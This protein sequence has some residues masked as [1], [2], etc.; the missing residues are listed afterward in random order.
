MKIES[1]FRLLIKKAN[2]EGRYSTANAYQCTLH[3]YQQFNKNTLVTF[4]E[5]T[6]EHMK[7]YEQDMMKRGLKYN[8]ISLYFRMLRAVCNQAVKQ[9]IAQINTFDLFQHVFMGNKPTLKRAI[10][11]AIISKLAEADLSNEPQL[12]YCR[13]LFLL[14]VYLQGIP[15]I[16]L[17]YMRKSDITGN[18]L[19]YFRHKTGSSIRVT[20]ES[21][22]AKIMAK[23][24]AQCKDSIYV[25]PII[26]EVGE[27]GHKQYCSALRLYN[28]HLNQL[29]MQLNLGVKLSS[30][31]ARHTWATTAK[32]IGIPISII[33]TGMGHS[34]EKMTS[35][36]LDSF[37]DKKT[38]DANKKVIAA[39][40]KERKSEK[41]PILIR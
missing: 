1:F 32:N 4:E 34:S 14:S 40:R 25:L 39:I 36:Y 26:T 6:Q 35:I 13:D 19:I 11:P 23:Y 7:Q 31:V 33:S 21:C 41:D 10:K 37:E 5:L 18:R 2:Q 27:K 9:G 17:A 20:I 22:G 29:S 24:A 30:Y 3:S 38:S 8:T 12:A 15:F 16:D 28:K